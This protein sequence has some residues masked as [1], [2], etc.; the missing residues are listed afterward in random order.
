V[1]GAWRVLGS[2]NGRV[3]LLVL[4]RFTIKLGPVPRA[5]ATQVSIGLTACS[6]GADLSLSTVNSWEYGT[7]SQ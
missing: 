1:T 4:N 3:R 2:F 5:P 6:A 7:V